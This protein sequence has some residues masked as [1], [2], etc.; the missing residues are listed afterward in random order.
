M[1]KERLSLTKTHDITFGRRNTPIQIRTTHLLAGLLLRFSATYTMTGGSGVGTMFADALFRLFQLVTVTTGG[2]PQ[3]TLTGQT[4]NAIM[5][6]LYPTNYQHDQPVSLA[7]AASESVECF[8][9]L[10]FAQPHSFDPLAT[11]LPS[12]VWPQQ[13][14]Q[15]V[16][17][18]DA[19]GVVAS[20]EDG[21]IG[22][23]AP[24]LEVREVQVLDENMDPTVRDFMR[25][26]QTEQ[27]IGAASSREQVYLPGMTPG[28]EI[29]LVLVET[30]DNTGAF[31]YT[32]T[33]V[34][35]LR[36]IVAGQ[37]VQEKESFDLLRQINKRDYNLAALMSGCVFLDSASDRGTA[38]GELW[39]VSEGDRPY[40]EVTTTAACKVRVTVIA[41]QRQPY[42]VA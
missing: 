1:A 24:Q 21:V 36:L 15:L 13:P 8:L 35:H 12:Y 26:V 19:A 23:T 39:Y 10:P 5:S 3:L 4:I 6:A 22:F 38:L 28:E 2:E 18:F 11:A 34:S 40:M 27:N 16:V 41:I 14:Q 33:I 37:D 31:V 7:A 9:Y 25:I 17:D 20:G 30:F 32:N 42:D 29:R